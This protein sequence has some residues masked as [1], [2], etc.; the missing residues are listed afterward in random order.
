VVQE[1]REDAEPTL[2]RTSSRCDNTFLEEYLSLDDTPHSLPAKTA[3][4]HCLP[5]FTSDVRHLLAHLR[6]HLR[7]AEKEEEEAMV[8]PLLQLKEWEV[9]VEAD[10]LRVECSLG[11]NFELVEAVAMVGM[12]VSAE[13][14]LRREGEK[15]WGRVE[16]TETA[17]LSEECVHR[18]KCWLEDV[19][20][21]H[22]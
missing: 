1:L 13:V 7:R 17:D 18:L 22:T 3:D 15:L 10:L 12:L 8:D 4:E 19:L 20:A 16:V 9:S 21:M 5:L 6:A 11:W 2:H 14:R